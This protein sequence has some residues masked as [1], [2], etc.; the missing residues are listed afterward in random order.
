MKGKFDVTR[1]RGIPWGLELLWRS[2]GCIGKRR[3][4]AKSWHRLDQE[5]LSLTVK[6]GREN[7]D[8][9]GIAARPGQRVHQS[10]ADHI[11]CEPKDR[12][13]RCRLLCGADC[14]IPADH[15][16]FRPGIDQFH[17]ETRNSID[18]LAVSAKLDHKVLALNEAE[19]SKFIEK[20]DV[21]GR[22]ARTG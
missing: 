20:S 1:S 18:I 5:F 6:L 10:R 9:G 4:A 13:R 7:A 17:R 21:L 22:V 15:D 8:P 3:H 12:D 14:R 11:V 2:R 19:P 16:D